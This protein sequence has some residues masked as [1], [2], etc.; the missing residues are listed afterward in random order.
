MTRRSIR[1]EKMIRSATLLKRD[2]PKPCRACKGEG[3][4][5][6]PGGPSRGEGYVTCDDCRGT[7]EHTPRR[8]E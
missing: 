3:L 1:V 5:W 8:M 4:R 2:E 6:E 7:G